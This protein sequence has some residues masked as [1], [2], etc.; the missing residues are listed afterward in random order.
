MSF[1]A[2]YDAAEELQNEERL[3][4]LM[5]IMASEYDSH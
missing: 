2:S 5:G 1:A 3:A 4:E